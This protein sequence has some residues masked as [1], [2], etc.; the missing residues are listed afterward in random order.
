[1]CFQKGPFAY[2]R[3]SKQGRAGSPCVLM[4][5][6]IVTITYAKSNLANLLPVEC[7]MKLLSGLIS[8]SHL[9]D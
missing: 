7:I 9:I 2:V 8:E 5:L 6:E 3:V 4:A 1:M